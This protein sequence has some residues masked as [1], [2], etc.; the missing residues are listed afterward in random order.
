MNKTLTIAR[1]ELLNLVAKPSFWIGLLLVPIIAGAGALFVLATSGVALA[2]S[3]ANREAQPKV[4]GVVDAAGV[5]TAQPAA[6]RR[7]PE[8]KL[9]VSE[10]AAQQALAA[11]EINGFYVIETSFMRDGAVRFVAGQ[12][13]PIES[14]DRTDNFERTLRLALLG[15]DTGALDRFEQPLGEVKSA[16][17]APPD[18]ASTALGFSPVPL[19]AGLV[20]MGSLLGSSAYLMQSVSTEKENRVIEVLMSSVTPTQ[21]LTGKILGLGVVGFV[22]LAI[23]LAT[24][25]PALTAL[26]QFPV[27]AQFLGAVTPSAVFWSVAL[28][29]TGYFI[30]AALMAGLG[31]LM[32]GLKEA[33]Q[34]SVVVMIP[35]I[36]P[37]YLSSA[38]LNS[39]NGPLSLFL[40][41]FPLTAPVAMPMRLFA[42]TL[43]FWQPLLAV[44][45]VALTAVGVTRLAAR[46]FRA[47]TLL[48]GSQPTPAQILEA[49]R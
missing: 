26:S 14:E 8:L 34:W 28:F 5:F 23:W 47:Q 15:N 40:S 33:S 31:A 41:F 24:G 3:A 39:P 12:F 29:M 46:V 9:F 36:L 6:L 30:Y 4:K 2:T 10:E 43:P 16:R 49:L 18:P 1:R 37:L 22:Q 7:Q 48:R 25:L 11:N 32:P 45:L 21:L 44:V 42:E 19:I 38:L 20:F 17:L 27:V 35:L 13:S